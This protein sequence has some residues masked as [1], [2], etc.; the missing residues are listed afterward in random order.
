MSGMSGILGV[1]P[2][3]SPVRLFLDS[4]EVLNGVEQPV[5][6]LPV[7]DVGV[8]EQAVHLAV[9]VLNG[10]L[11]A[12]EASGLRDLNNFSTRFSLTIPQKL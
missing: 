5:P 4:G 10:D 1:D 7:L 2:L 11:E 9:D 3:Q 12:V 8:D 6:L